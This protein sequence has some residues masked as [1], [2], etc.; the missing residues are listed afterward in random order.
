MATRM[1]EVS[2]EIAQLVGQEGM[3]VRLSDEADPHVA[4][5]DW[6]KVLVADYDAVQSA[7]DEGFI[8]RDPDNGFLKMS[9]GR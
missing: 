4:T 1:D 8:I 7:L 2:Q 6:G 5:D 3:P 9:G